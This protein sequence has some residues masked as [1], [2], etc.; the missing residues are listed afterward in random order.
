MDDYL[1]SLFKSLDEV[2]GGHLVLKPLLSYQLKEKSPPLVI[3]WSGHLFNLT[4]E[5]MSDSCT[6]VL[7]VDSALLGL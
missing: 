5:F 3:V 1:P 7:S 6:S 4:S 2:S